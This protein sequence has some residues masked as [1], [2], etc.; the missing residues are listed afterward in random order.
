[1]I[2]YKQVN[3]YQANN[4]QGNK[5]IKSIQI[6]EDLHFFIAILTPWGRDT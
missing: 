6:D 3:L 4:R 1:M 5:N 2:N